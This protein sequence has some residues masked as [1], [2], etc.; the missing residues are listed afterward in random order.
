MD[1]LVRTHPIPYHVQQQGISSYEYLLPEL[2]SE[3]QLECTIVEF[4]KSLS[5]TVQRVRE[6]SKAKHEVSVTL[7]NGLHL[8]AIG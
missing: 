5:V 3:E 7:L 1:P 4:N 8:V 2:P 6:R